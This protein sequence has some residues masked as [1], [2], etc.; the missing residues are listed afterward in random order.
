MPELEIKDR[1]SSI[2]VSR[3]AKGDFSMKIKIYFDEENKDDVI[4]RAE[5]IYKELK[6]RFK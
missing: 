1:P 4:N 5:K 3:N 6:E 2:E